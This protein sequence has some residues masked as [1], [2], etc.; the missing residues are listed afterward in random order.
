MQYFLQALQ[1]LEA[2]EAACPFCGTTVYA[3]KH[4]DKGLCCERK[5]RAYGVGVDLLKDDL[6]PRDED[7]ITGNLDFLRR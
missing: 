2:D 3:S 5:R 7:E 4:L 6:E 1:K